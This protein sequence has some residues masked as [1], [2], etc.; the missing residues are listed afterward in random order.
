M[1]KND[2]GELFC[3]AVDT[4]IKERL[5]EISF[6]QTITCTIVEDKDKANGK[7]KVSNG[8]TKF[9]AYSTDTTLSKNASV[10]VQIPGGDWSQE[11]I[12]LCRKPIGDEKPISYKDPFNSFVDITGNLITQTPKQQG[13]LANNPEPNKVIIWAYNCDESPTNY[14]EDGVDLAGYTRLGLKASFQAWL[15]ELGA[16]KGSYG[17]RLRIEGIA[18]DEKGIAKDEKITPDET[19]DYWKNHLTQKEISSDA[20]NLLLNQFKL[21]FSPKDVSYDDPYMTESQEDKLKRKFN[22]IIDSE[23]KSYTIEQIAE[24]VIE[25]ESFKVSYYDLIFD[26]GEMPGNPY[27]YES[28]YQQEKLFDISHIYKIRKIELEFYEKP[29]TFKNS[30]GVDIPWEGLPPNIFVKDIYVSLGYDSSSFETD[31][32]MLYSLD[33]SQYIATEDPLEDNHKKVE[34]RWIHKLEDGSFKSITMNDD[35]DYELS[36]YKKELGNRSDTVYSGVDWTPLSRQIV[37]KGSFAYPIVDKEWISY[38]N[39]AADPT[40]T[41]GL[42]RH[43]GFNYTWLLPDINKLEEQVKVVLTYNDSVFYSNILSFTNRREVVSK[44]TV[45]AIQALTINCEDD[46]YGNYLVY[47]LGGQLTDISMASEPREFKAYFNSVLDETEDSVAAQLT[48]AE[49]IEW[50]IPTINT[51]IVLPK[52]YL[53]GDEHNYIDENGFQHIFRYGEPNNKYNIINENT[54]RYRISS[55]YT[56]AYSNNTIKCVIIKDKVTYTAVKELTFGPS[57]TAGT[58]YTFV[59]D[60]DNGETALTLDSDFKE[61]DTIPAVFARARLY[62]YKGNE[63]ED[64]ESKNIVWSWQDKD[65][66]WINLS[67]D[68]AGISILTE[69][70]RVELKLKDSPKEVPA[71]NYSILKAT[72]KKSVQSGDGG[73]G[74]FDL[75]A[76]L[77][78]PIRSSRKYQFISG[79]TIISYNSLG[80]LDTYFQNPY[81]IHV[82]DTYDKSEQK[83]TTVPSTWTI[84]PEKI[85]KGNKEEDNAYLPVLQVDREGNTYI[86]PVNIYIEDAFDNICIVGSVKDKDGKDIKV[87]SQP[88]YVYQNKYPSSIINDWD[89]RLKIDEKN[90]AILAAKV[91][92]GRKEN[93]NTFSGVM[94]GDWEN[95][96]KGESSESSLETGLYGFKR[97]VSTFGFK[98]DGTAFIGKPGVG[99]L[100]FDGNKSVITSNRMAIGAGGME[101]DFDDGRIE[102]LRPTRYYYTLYAD[103]WSEKKQEIKIDDVESGKALSIKAHNANTS[104]SDA[105]TIAKMTINAQKNKVIITCAGDVPTIDIPIEIT[106]ISASGDSDNKISIDASAITHPFKIGDYFKVAWDGSIKATNGDFEGKITSDEGEIGG[107]IINENSLYK[108]D[109]HLYSDTGVIEGATLRAGRIESNEG[110]RITLSGYFLLEN[111]GYMGELGAEYTAGEFTGDGIGFAYG[112]ASVKATSEN[113]GLANDCGGI[114]ISKNNGAHIFGKEGYGV[115][116][117]DRKSGKIQ[118]GSNDQS[119]TIDVYGSKIVFHTKNASDQEGIYAR[120]APDESSSSSTEN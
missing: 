78:I 46:S 55:F 81:E 82:V 6:D 13:L 114:S 67:V 15:K 3:Q 73:W 29:E 5:N 70:N 72:L 84:G 47:D 45:D 87:W 101:L 63:I 94:M 7:Y 95:H 51:M 21:I 40:N 58:D 75:N 10:Y 120:F 22:F 26:C 80:Y 50:I 28:F 62:D 97:G 98:V 71:N 66:E 74:D 90:N 27:N 104:Q 111:G 88:I 43:P 8:S 65:N 61:G 107:W 38:N 49:Q 91:V 76:Y 64:I 36:W 57:G 18:N 96:E 103:Y 23:K 117:T 17:L 9:D 115:K 85:K 112:T 109:V 102:M 24:L 31:T 14:K 86:R 4:I 33:S 92:A 83:P 105:F 79:T 2:Y 89:G 37:S 42:P 110:G 69:K 16:V 48:E 35:I 39:I 19:K 68:N 100:E 32:L 60:F 106:G 113:V 119:N 20:K 59:L 118:I 56:Q 99:R 25:Y 44:P 116:I 1:P 52:E 93:D 41:G 12:I 34:L 108:G 77:P 11:K 30:L 53:S 54:Q